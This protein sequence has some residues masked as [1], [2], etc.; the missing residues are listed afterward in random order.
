MRLSLGSDVTAFGESLVAAVERAGLRVVPVASDDGLVWQLM[1]PSSTNKWILCLGVAP[2]PRRREL[3]ALLADTYL[4]ARAHARNTGAS[5]IAF[6]AA[7]RITEAVGDELR[8]YAAAVLPDDAW[9]FVDG[10]GTFESHRTPWEGSKLAFVAD[11]QP[12][13]VGRAPAY[14]PFSDLGQWLL[15]VLLARRLPPELMTAPRERVRSGNALARLAGVSVPTATRLIAH[16]RAEHFIEKGA[17]PVELVRLDDLLPLWAQAH[18]RP[19]AELRARW[20]LPTKDSRAQLYA[21]LRDGR[22]TD[23]PYGRIALALYAAAEVH[24]QGFVHGAPT[25]LYVERRPEALCEALGLVPTESAERADVFI[26]MPRYSESCFRAAVVRDGLPVTDI[27][28]CWMDVLHH[29]ARGREQALQIMKD[30]LEPHL[31]GAKE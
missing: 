11:V 19:P 20:L 21:V 14:D 29:P 13:S 24:G 3:R 22:R 23:A 25:H 6:V 30:V 18:A 5:P 10:A 27:L 7:P 12:A 15:K 8:R 4:R 2:E 16:L 31:L 17:A 1:R 9:G 28:Q 26:R